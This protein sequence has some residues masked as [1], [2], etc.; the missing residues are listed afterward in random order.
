MSAGEVSDLSDDDIKI[1]DKAVPRERCLD[2]RL[3]Q[4]TLR[5]RIQSLEPCI[6]QTHNL[7]LP[8]HS[9]GHG[10]RLEHEQDVDKEEDGCCCQEDGTCRGCC[11]ILGCVLVTD[12]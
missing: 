6:V 9:V 1:S 8:L 3:F 7:R 12:G 11:G 10:Q 5:A 4:L 2:T